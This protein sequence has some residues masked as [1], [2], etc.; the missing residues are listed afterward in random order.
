MKVIDLTNPKIAE[1]WE[2]SDGSITPASQAIGE[3]ARAKGFNVIRFGSDAYNLSCNGR[4]MSTRQEVI[5][6]TERALTLLALRL[7]V[8]PSYGVYQHAQDQL[9]RILLQLR[10]PALPDVG[11]RDWVDIG[12]MSVREI[13]VSEPELANALMDADYDFKHALD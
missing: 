3:K 10:A 13:E 1:K 8:A 5:A 7:T 11:A 2:Y 6:S 4:Q 12:L 9:S